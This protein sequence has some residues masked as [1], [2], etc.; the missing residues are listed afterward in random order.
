LGYYS[1]GRLSEEKSFINYGILGTSFSGEIYNK[2]K[3][4]NYEGIVP[5]IKGN[6][7]I[8]GMNTFI[9]DVNDPFKYGFTI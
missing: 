1:K 7:F 3:I 2:V 4:G 9:L 5:K 6:A 8:T